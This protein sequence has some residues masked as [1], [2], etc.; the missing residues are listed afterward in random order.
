MPE[1]LIP[2]HPKLVHFPIALFLTAFGFEIL[3]ILLKKK[4]FHQCAICMYV[5]ASL[6]T[7]LVVRTGIWES[8]RLNLNHPLLDKHKLIA[9]WTMWVSLMSL[10]LLWLSFKEFSKYFRI[11]F[12]IGLLSVSGLV[13]YAGHLGG[14][15]VY[16]YGVGIEE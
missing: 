15:M 3:S 7:P 13:G 11:I 9:L 2:L 1:F 4:F 16:E 12:L 10:P 6:M 5:V 14:Q 8:E